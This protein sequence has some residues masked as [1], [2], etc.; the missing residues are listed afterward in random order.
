M[1]NL[2]ALLSVLFTSFYLF[3]QL[4]IGITRREGERGVSR[5]VGFDHIPLEM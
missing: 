1:L 3:L 2:F 4:E 5:V